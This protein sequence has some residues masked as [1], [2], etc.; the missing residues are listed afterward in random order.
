MGDEDAKDLRLGLPNVRRTKT[1]ARF[2]GD[3]SRQK[4]SPSTLVNNYIVY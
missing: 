1:T 2:L 4:K 3:F